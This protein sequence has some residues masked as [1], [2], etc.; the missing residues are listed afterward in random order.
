MTQDLK[1]LIERLEELDA[2]R[3]PGDWTIHR[4]GIFSETNG[5]VSNIN[6]RD[7]SDI[8]FANLVCN[9]ALPALKAAQAREAE[10][11]ERVATLQQ[12]LDGVLK[13][14]GEEQQ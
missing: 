9:E 8:H 5:Y 3:T 1:P 10:L 4:L 12:E 2:K 14:I 7:P 11:V 13:M 6:P